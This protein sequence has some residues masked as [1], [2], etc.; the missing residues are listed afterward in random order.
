MSSMNNSNRGILYNI[1]GES[2]EVQLQRSIQSVRRHYPEIPIHVARGDAQVGLLQKSRMGSLSPF[3]STLY[4]DVDTIVLGNLDY[5]FER[6]EQFGL[7]CAICECS[8]LRRYGAEQQDRTEYNTGVIFFTSTARE[9]FS[10]WERM[11]PTTPSKSLWLTTTGEPHGLQYDDQASF[12]QAIM[13]TRWN[14]FVLSLNW[15]FRPVFQPR[16]FAPVKIWHDYRDPPPGFAELN[17]A[18]ENGNRPV[19]Q[20]EFGLS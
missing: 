15:N 4:L 17:E 19:S 3:Q 6:A 8:W 11:A 16:I 9:V 13:A 14:P 7:A 12:A 10:T 5:A 20:I 18:C 2:C 1:W